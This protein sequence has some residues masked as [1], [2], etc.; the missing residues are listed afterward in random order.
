MTGTRPGPEDNECPYCW[1]EGTVKRRYG[2]VG[3]GPAKIVKTKQC[4]RCEGSGNDQ[5]WTVSGD[6]SDD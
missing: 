1:G 6:G 3:P 2:T 5:S 4:P